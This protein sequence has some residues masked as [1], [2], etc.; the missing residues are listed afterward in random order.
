MDN[1][2]NNNTNNSQ[3]DIKVILEKHKSLGRFL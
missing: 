2:E 1:I 3:Q